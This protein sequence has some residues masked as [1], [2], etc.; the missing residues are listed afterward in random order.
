MAAVVSDNHALVWY[1]VEPEKLSP[2]ASAAFDQAVAACDPIYFPSI[3]IVEITYLVEKGRLPETVLQRLSEAL[4]RPD[5]V[6]VPVP[7]DLE[8]A[9]T[10]RQIPRQEVLEMPDRIVA[11]T[12]LYLQ[13][14]LVTRD[15]A[16][17]ASGITTIW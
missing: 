1:I 17:R 13:L 5:A 16:I 2:D 4:S 3:A 7:L 8:V 12:A 6:L 14:V 15:L 11:A 10:V 9:R